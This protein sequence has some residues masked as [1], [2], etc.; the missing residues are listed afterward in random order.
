MISTQVIASSIGIALLVA[1]VTSSVYWLSSG[2]DYFIV[3]VMCNLV[4]IVLA[5]AGW[6]GALWKK[7]DAS[8]VPNTWGEW[9]V[10]FVGGFVFTIIFLSMDCGG[11]L[12]N[13]RPEFVCNG[14]P[15]ISVIF[16]FAAVGM[17]AIALPSA[18]RA[19]ILANFEENQRVDI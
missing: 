17:M 18:V 8:F 14:Q 11:S 7:K 6:T 3:A 19:W 4:A 10:I 2:S 5:I 9:L 13:F 16:T 12:P 15:G 1:L